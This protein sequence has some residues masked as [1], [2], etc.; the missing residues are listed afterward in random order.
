MRKLT[1]KVEKFAFEI[2]KFTQ[3]MEN[4]FQTINKFV[5]MFLLCFNI[6]LN[7]IG[8]IFRNIFLILIYY[9]SFFP[10]II[11]KGT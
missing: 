7:N 11:R 6:N 1:S 3:R 9:L 5:H 10:Q 8:K 4:F 2:E